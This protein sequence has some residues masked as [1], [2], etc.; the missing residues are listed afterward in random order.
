M[1][2]S[3]LLGLAVA[4]M[5]VA[6]T[7][8]LF[9]QTEADFQCRIENGKITIIGYTGSA[10]NV[11]IPGQIGGLP[12]TAIGGAEYVYEDDQYV[13][14]FAN[15]QL[16]SVAIPNGVTVIGHGAFAGNRLTGVTIPNG[17]T[18]IGSGSFYKNQ[19]T[20]V[21][22]PDGVTVIGGSAF[23]SNQLT[24]VTIGNA[25][26]EI[27]YMAFGENKLTS[28]TIPGSVTRII[29]FAF[30]YNPL[31]SVTIGADVTFGRSGFSG[32]LAGVY[33]VEQTVKSVIVRIAA[34]T[35]FKGE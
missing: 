35:R 10:K 9:G 34:I 31:T 29:D 19:L 23:E 17:V 7:G 2:K 18:E 22:I 16:T 4:V 27:G 30:A 3:V 1:K 15:Q 32:D 12:V 13:G 14:S 28:V 26:T 33:N 20:R 8:T 25:V 21:T 6:E 24:S 11:T 5:A